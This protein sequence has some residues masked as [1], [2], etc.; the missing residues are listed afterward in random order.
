[1]KTQQELCDILGFIAE[2][3]TYQLGSGVHTS[4]VIRN[5]QRIGEALGVDVQLSSFQ[6]STILTVLDTVSGESAT[7]VVAIPSLPISFERNSDLSALSWDALDEGL[8]LDEIRSRYRTL[9][10][11]P[12][13]D[14]IFTLVVV[15]LAN[16]SFC[17]LFGG[18]WTA[19][20]IVFTATLVGFAV[21]QR[22]Q[23]HAVN[24]FLVFACSAF[25]ASL[26]ATA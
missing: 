6:K 11:K 3:A 21:K 5:A 2:Y 9:V 22:M 17:K 4:R 19:V 8:S 13:M 20:G 25:V 15:G 10:D 26:C 23:A 24:H 7:R 14:P 1:M 12:R 16:A 18:D